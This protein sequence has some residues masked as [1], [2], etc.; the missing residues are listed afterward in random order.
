MIT[1]ALL[2]IW[3]AFIGWLFDLIPTFTLPNDFIAGA[4]DVLQWINWINRYIPLDTLFLIVPT[5]LVVW[6][7]SAVA[8]AVLQLL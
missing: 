7:G 1:S 5:M 4:Y 6:L 3:Y 2:D 8:S